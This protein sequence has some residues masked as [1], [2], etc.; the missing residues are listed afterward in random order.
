MESQIT[1]QHP[2]FF[3]G[4]SNLYKIL[5]QILLAKMELIPKINTSNIPSYTLDL[6]DPIIKSIENQSPESIKA[7]KESECRKDL[8][9][10]S[11]ILWPKVLEQAY[12]EQGYVIEENSISPD[13]L[14]IQLSYTSQ[15]LYEAANALSWGNKETFINRL[16]AV[17]RF[18]TVHMMPT[19][20]QC[21][22]PVTD[23]MRD[24]IITT[25]AYIRPLII[26]LLK[27][28]QKL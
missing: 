22:N 4:L 10:S 15:L 17:H 25:I 5:A 27:D 7:L 14:A 1:L 11:K 6:I 19:I 26:S 20:S 3:L 16:I 13:H 21:Q 12:R 8:D 28:R 9:K 23:K 24:I 2:S 18:L